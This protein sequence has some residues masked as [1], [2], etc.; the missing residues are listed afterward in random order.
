[1]AELLS[2]SNSSK[3]KAETLKAEGNAFHIKG[4]NEKAYSKYSE[5]IKLDPNN[6]VLYANRAASALA[7]KE[8][9]VVSITSHRVPFQY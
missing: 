2:V 1:M 8:Y 9:E 3:V 4:E 5:A 7:M 6:A